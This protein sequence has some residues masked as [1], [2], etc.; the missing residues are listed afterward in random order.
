M[1]LTIRDNLKLAES[2]H[3]SQKKINK[4]YTKIT[5][6]S[7]KEKADST[8]HPPMNVRRATYER[9]PNLWVGW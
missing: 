5:A 2:H 6:D 4:Q 3:E 1:T 7:N 8:I 9:A